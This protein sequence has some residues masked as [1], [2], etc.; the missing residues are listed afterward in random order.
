VFYLDIKSKKLKNF[1]ISLFSV[2]FFLAI[3]IQSAVS[4]KFYAIVKKCPKCEYTTKKKVQ[5]SQEFFP[6]YFEDLTSCQ[7]KATMLKKRKKYTISC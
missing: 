2:L 6:F 3:E 5:E 1:L 4:H 7:E